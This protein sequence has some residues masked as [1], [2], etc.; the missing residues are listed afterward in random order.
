VGCGP[1]DP[2]QLH[3]RTDARQ[4]GCIVDPSVISQRPAEAEDRAIPGRRESLGSSDR[5]N[6]GPFMALQCRHRRIVR[7]RVLL[8]RHLAYLALP[9]IC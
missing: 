9:F 3:R 4:Q 7:A 1:A 6:T 5:C 2:A 8:P